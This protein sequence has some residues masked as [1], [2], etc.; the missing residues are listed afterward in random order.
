MKL[1][2]KLLEEYKIYNSP[3]LARFAGNKL[4]VS[5]SPAE[6][7]RAAHFAKWQVV[8]IGFRTDP[9][10]HWANYGNKTF[11]VFCRE[12]KLSKLQEAIAWT[13]QTYNIDITDK[14]PFGDYH[15]KGTLEKIIGIIKNEVK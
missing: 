11:D 15:P 4:Y 10:S 1:T 2:K 8:G 13:K 14:D 7:G 9:K 6:N 5:Y 3:N 12:E